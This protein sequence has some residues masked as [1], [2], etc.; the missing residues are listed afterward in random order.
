MNEFAA[1]FSAEAAVRLRP[2]EISGFELPVDADRKIIVTARTIYHDQQG[3]D[4]IPGALEF[5]VRGYASNLPEALNAHKSANFC[6]NVLSVA[7][8]AIVKPIELV[9]VW[10]ITPGANNRPFLRA[11]TQ[12]RRFPKRS[13]GPLTLR[14]FC[15]RE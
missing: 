5:L 2:G 7:G 6:A 1:L 11:A 8:N 9:Q 10:D 13:R 4:A 15:A 12:D 14:A 3:T